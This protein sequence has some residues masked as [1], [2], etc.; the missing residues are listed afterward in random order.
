MKD[1]IITSQESIVKDTPEED[2]QLVMGH[3]RQNVD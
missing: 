2:Y 3:Y 1:D